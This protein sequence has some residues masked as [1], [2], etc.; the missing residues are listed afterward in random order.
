MHSHKKKGLE[1]KKKRLSA[2]FKQKY[3]NSNRII[4]NLLVLD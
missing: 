3:L 1:L 2:K 4:E